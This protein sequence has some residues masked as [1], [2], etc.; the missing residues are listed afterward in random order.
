MANFDAKVYNK[1]DYQNY[2][3]KILKTN[4]NL[5]RIQTLYS[6]LSSLNLFE[7]MN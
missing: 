6:N 7:L 3:V 5:D 1:N 2:D 4:F